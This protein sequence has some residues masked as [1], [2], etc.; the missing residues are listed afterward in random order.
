MTD[1]RCV[2][3]ERVWQLRVRA[4]L[5]PGELAE[6]A[7]VA[8]WTVYAIERGVTDE[9]RPVDVTLSTLAGL[10]AG[11]GVPVGVLVGERPLPLHWPVGDV[12]WRQVRREVDQIQSQFE[13]VA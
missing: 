12:F 10:A 11:L 3:A 2:V 5:T 8:A 6:R 7:G 9:G 1:S 13:E 4:N